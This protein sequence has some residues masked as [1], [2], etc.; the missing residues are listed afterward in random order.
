MAITPPT[1]SHQA[2]IGLNKV[3]VDDQGRLLEDVACRSCGYNLRTR[4]ISDACPECGNPVQFS[5]YGE[6]LEYADAA[7]VGRICRGAILTGWAWRVLGLMVIALLAMALFSVWWGVTSSMRHVAG[8]T[9]GLLLVT[10]ALATLGAWWL[11]S[12][13]PS[14]AMEAGRSRLARLIASGS[15]LPAL[16]AVAMIAAQLN[17]ADLWLLL[18]SL[19]GALGCLTVGEWRVHHLASRMTD[20]DLPHQQ[21]RLYLGMLGGLLALILLLAGDPWSSVL[22]PCAC[23]LGFGGGWPLLPLSGV[24]AWKW[25]RWTGQMLVEFRSLRTINRRRAEQMQEQHTRQQA[26]RSRD[27]GNQAKGHQA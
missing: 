12:V 25:W 10:H 16:V 19:V 13:D 24:A 18:A 26:W 9:V 17:D 27:D 11:W 8:V 14:A 2:R 6:Q 3:R 15:W 5:L 7:W 4:R 21:A 22:L 23:L 1:T 20:L